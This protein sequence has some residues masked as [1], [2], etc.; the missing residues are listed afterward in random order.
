MVYR[1]FA[2]VIIGYAKLLL[3]IAINA[4]NSMY[5]VILNLNTFQG[6]NFANLYKLLNIHT[7]IHTH[8]HAY[9]HTYY[10]YIHIHTCKHACIHTHTQTHTYLHTYIH[11]YIHINT[12]LYMHEGICI[13]TYV[14][15]CVYIF[16]LLFHFI[17]IVEKKL[18]R[19]TSSNHSFEP[20]AWN[21]VARHI[22]SY[23]ILCIVQYMV[24][25]G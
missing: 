9:T 4:V 21:I 6:M 19:H 15:M 14:C 8:I 7:Y 25:T 2:L 10:K 18:C 12:S 22:C 3:Y 16:S 5:T 24:A 11:M 1:N 17:Y 20:I 23:Y 13:C